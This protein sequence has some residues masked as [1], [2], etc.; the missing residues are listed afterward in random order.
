MLA[1]EECLKPSPILQ[2]AIEELL[3]I[4]D[5]S[6]RSVTIYLYLKCIHALR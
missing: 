5:I 6:S 1:M 4:L 3:F 2:Q